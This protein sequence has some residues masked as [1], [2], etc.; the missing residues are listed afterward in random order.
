MTRLVQTGGRLSRA[1]V[2]AG[3]AAC[4]TN[5]NTPHQ[6]P[7][8][9]PP[10]GEQFA[11]PPNQGGLGTIEGTITQGGVLIQGIDVELRADDG[12]TL[13]G[14]TD[15]HG[16]YVFT[17]LRP[18]K[19]MVTAMTDDSAHQEPQRQWLTLQADAVAHA[20]FRVEPYVPDSGPCC[21]PYGAPPAR[22]RVV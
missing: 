11:Q 2:F 22:R 4:Y 5:A 9:P 14:R 10:D 18:G 21:K 7:P 15:A 19:Y 3:A 20:D 17:G 16:R 6:Q 8:P 13:S 12:D 1:A